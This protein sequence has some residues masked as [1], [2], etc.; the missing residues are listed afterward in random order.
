MT[1]TSRLLALVL[2]YAALVCVVVRAVPDDD[3]SNLRADD[4][5]IEDLQKKLDKLKR[6]EEDM[7]IQRERMAHKL[8]LIRR[9]QR[10]RAQLD[11]KKI[12][13]SD[14]HN[15]LE[16]TR[17]AKELAEEKRQSTYQEKEAIAATRRDTERLI[18]STRGNS[19]T[20]LQRTEALRKLQQNTADQEKA[21]E[22]K[23]EEALLV[24]K[25]LGKQF[26][27]K[28][29]EK[30]IIYNSESLPVIVKGSIQ[31]ATEAF[32]P[33]ANK[34]EKVVEA[35][36]MLSHQVTERL[37]HIMPSIKRSPFYQG[38]LF[39]LVL[40]FPTV[41][42]TWLVLK[43]H[44]RLSQLTVAHYVVAINLY[45]GTMS[46]LCL[47]M[48]LLSS[49]DILIVFRHRSRTAFEAFTLLH[50]LFFVLHLFLHGVVSRNSKDYGQLVSMFCVGLH[51]FVHAYKR[52]IFN[53][54]P[55]IGAPAY[56]LY[57]VI[58]L[59]TL[60]DRGITIIE[61]AVKDDKETRPF[62]TFPSQTSLL[63]AASIS[64]VQ[65]RS[66]KRT[67]YFA[68]LPVF[69]NNQANNSQDPSGKEV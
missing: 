44:A 56:F 52:T 68:G 36:E 21:M 18:E 31:K 59:Y 55:N 49:N 14:A 43:I 20:V 65:D 12:E 26:K 47:F 40:L 64:S 15:E 63:G 19:M 3:D 8:D 46:V 23:R 67:V 24:L 51:F 60:Y 33:F 39:Y 13:L 7:R 50:A 9:V 6:D 58:F 32:A 37:N 17:K 42:A 34:F 62:E 66:A 28:G 2:L 10:A 48:S 57:S 1:T 16:A 61:A 4:P 69:S 27:D 35:E 11:I 53:Q 29:L 54:D 5:S 22:A 41:L 30:W 45:F 38:I 25:N